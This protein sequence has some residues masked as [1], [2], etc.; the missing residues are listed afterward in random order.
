MVY[1]LNIVSPCLAL[2]HLHLTS[3]SF[4]LALGVYLSFLLDGAIGRASPSSQLLAID[5]DANN[6]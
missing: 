3:I 1:L 4:L 6:S 2:S 5:I